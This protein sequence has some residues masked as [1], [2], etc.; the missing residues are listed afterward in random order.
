MNK[1]AHALFPY[2]AVAVADILHDPNSISVFT[3]QY[4]FATA[5]WIPGLP[6][7]LVVMVMLIA[8]GILPDTIDKILSGHKRATH[9]RHRKNSGEWL[10]DSEFNEMVSSEKAWWGLHRTVSHWWPIPIVLYG[11]GLEPLAIGWASHLLLDAMTP[12]G[13]PKLVPIPSDKESGYMRIP[14]LSNLSWLS[15]LTTFLM[16]GIFISLCFT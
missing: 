15:S 16:V 7:T 4:I 14:Y 2:N 1:T 5:S 10:S 11:I 3:K 12:M 8:G 9:L 13:I 6:P